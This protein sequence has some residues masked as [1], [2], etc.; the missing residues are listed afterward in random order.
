[1]DSI[2]A[3]RSERGPGLYLFLAI[4]GVL[5]V[6]ENLEINQTVDVVP[7]GKSGKLLDFVLVN[8][9]LQMAGNTRVQ[10]AGR[11]RQNVDVIMLVSARIS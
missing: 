4:N 11:I 6:P 3:A 5:N 8:A 9:L 2:S 10:G 1:M 7:A